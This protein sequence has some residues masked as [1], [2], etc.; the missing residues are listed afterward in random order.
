LL[1]PPFKASSILFCL[2]VSELDIWSSNSFLNPSASLISFRVS[3]ERS[4]KTPSSL[5]ALAME[6]KRFCSGAPMSLFDL[7]VSLFPSVVLSLPTLSD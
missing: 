3:S 7:G 5:N 6:K 2:S 1:A 4:G